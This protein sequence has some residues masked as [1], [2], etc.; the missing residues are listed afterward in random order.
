MISRKSD[1]PFKAG[2]SFILS[3]IDKK[4]NH[5]FFFLLELHKR[6]ISKWNEDDK[7]F[8]PFHNFKTMLEKVTSRPYVTFVGVQGSGKSATVHHIA[9]QLQMDGYDIIPIKD[10]RHLETYCDPHNRQ[11]FVVDD[12]LGIF[13]LDLSKFDVLN[14]YQDRITDPEMPETKILLTCREVVYRNKMSANS[15]LFKKENVV[16]LHSKDHA[17]KNEDKHKLLQQYQLNAQLFTS[18]DLASSSNM[19]PLLCKLFTEQKYRVY[20]PRFFISPIPCILEI[21]DE[22]KTRKPVHYASLVLLMAYQNKLSSNILEN[23]CNGDL[24]EKTCTFLKECNVSSSVESFG[25]IDA[26]RELEGTYTRQCETE[27]NFIHDSMFEITAYHFGN[28]SPE[29]MLRFMSSEYI[30]NY[31]KVS[32]HPEKAKDDTNSFEDEHNEETEGHNEAIDL[33]IILQE[34][35]C[36]KLGERLLIDAKNGDLYTVFGNDALKHPS[37]MRAFIDV[38][39]KMTYKELYMTFLSELKETFQLN[40]QR[41]QSQSVCHGFNLGDYFNIH[42]L[43][44]D[45]KLI[46]CHVKNSVRAI[47]WVIY[48]GHNQLL[49]YIIDRV[50]KENKNVADLFQTPYNKDHNRNNIT[51]EEID[52]DDCA[53]CGLVNFLSE[54]AGMSC[55]QCIICCVKSDTNATNDTKREVCDSG[56]SGSSETENDTNDDTTTTNEKDTGS[57]ISEPV[58]IE[59]CR[60]LC[61]GCHSGDL[62]VVK[63]LLKY[64]NKDVLNQKIYYG[65]QYESRFPLE[66][67]CSL[68]HLQIAKELL[69]AG[70]NQQETMYQSV[71]SASQNGH[72]NV[73]EELIQNGVD[74]NDQDCTRTPLIAACQ[75]G[76]L[77]VVEVLIKAGADI[78]R[79]KEKQTPLKVA[80]QQRHLDIV[81]LLIKTGSDVYLKDGHSVSLPTACFD[82]TSSIVNDYIQAGADV[83]LKVGS[84]NTINGCVL[85]WKIS[86]S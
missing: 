20:G 71:L 23:E 56:M 1:E 64:M 8:L 35:Q 43:L 6:T 13:G 72:V 67:A 25:L 30:A 78:Y 4:K 61:I 28:G 3:I 54:N 57:E 37:V 17:L 31:I 85:Y 86:R 46:G 80:C 79:T 14:Q 51:E 68:G 81:K 75:E 19:F 12:A 58:T 41:S 45:K 47:S 33:C 66:I 70:A 82:G 48:F 36:A 29:L 11:V 24:N 73:V 15:F 10:I 69:K 84:Y 34:S 53:M 44:S 77:K 42:S 22:M 83:N 2:H 74:V 63:I 9:L 40:P 18:E 52:V 32:L 76:H 50:M 55:L 26:L 39:E 60:L 16:L 7:L 38:I 65:R 21:F 5:V 49:Q 62:G 27:F 59:Q